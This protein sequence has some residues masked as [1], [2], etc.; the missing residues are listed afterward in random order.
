MVFIDKCP[1][2]RAAFEE[3]VTIKPL[4]T[5]AT[6]LPAPGAALGAANGGGAASGGITTTDETNTASHAVVLSI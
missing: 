2:C 6:P 4:G 3:Y 5:A 1:V